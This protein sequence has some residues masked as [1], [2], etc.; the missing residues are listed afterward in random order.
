VLVPP[1]HAR[2]FDPRL[3]L[4]L[5]PI[6]VRFPRS[7]PVLLVILITLTTSG[8]R[9]KERKTDVNRKPVITH[10]AGRT[11]EE[12]YKSE[13][14]VVLLERGELQ[15]R[16]KKRAQRGK[17]D[18]CKNEDSCRVWCDMRQDQRSWARAHG[19]DRGINASSRNRKPQYTSQ[20]TP[21]YAS[22]DTQEASSY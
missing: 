6:L 18:S 17:E 19:F 15:A 4:I 5:F 22:H 3:F 14:G 20:D 8:T 10:R 13:R 7:L 2:P 16:A 21:G 1:S 9:T 11:N 12:S